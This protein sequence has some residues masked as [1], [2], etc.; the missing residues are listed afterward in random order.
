MK[1]TTKKGDNDLLGFGI[2]L[3]CIGVAFLVFAGGVYVGADVRESLF[4]GMQPNI[5]SVRCE[6]PADEKL[7]IYEGWNQ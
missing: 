1:K 7:R 6:P 3:L 2:F 4:R 5:I